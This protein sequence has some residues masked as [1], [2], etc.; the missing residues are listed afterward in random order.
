MTKAQR[1]LLL[2]LAKELMAR[3]EHSAGSSPNRHEE[4]FMMRLEELMENVE[5]EDGDDN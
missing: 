1:D 4:M 5:K 3:L 2:F